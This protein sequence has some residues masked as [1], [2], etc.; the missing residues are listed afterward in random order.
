MRRHSIDILEIRKKC[1]I[2]ESSPQGVFDC[3]HKLF[4]PEI[5]AMNDSSELPFTSI[6]FG[7]QLNVSTHTSD[8]HNSLD[9]P[10][11]YLIRIFIA[12]E[13]QQRKRLNAIVKL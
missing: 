11:A 2:E 13:Q 3:I 12:N 8:T 7:Y 5:Q 9:I 10:S 6:P 4:K 1:H